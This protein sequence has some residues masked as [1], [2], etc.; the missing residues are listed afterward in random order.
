MSHLQTT[1]GERR[2]VRVHAWLIIV[3]TALVVGLAAVALLSAPTEHV[4]ESEVEVMSRPTRG[5]P[6]PPTMGTERR[7]ALS[8]SVASEAADRMALEVAEAR[9][10]LSVSVVTDSEVLVL[11]YTAADP[12]RALDGA[13]AFTSSYVAE[14]NADQRTRIVDVITEP[15]LLPAPGSGVRPFVLLGA[16]LLAG[17]GLG[18][19]LAFAWDRL[20]DRIRSAGELVR[21]GLPVLVDRLVLPSGGQLRSSALSSGEQGYLATRVGSL[22]EHRRDGVTVLVTCPRSSSGVAPVASLTASSLAASGRRVVLVDLTGEVAEEAAPWSTT[23]SPAPGGERPGLGD[24]LSG[25]CSPEAAMRPTTVEG[26][27]VV[28]PGSSLDVASADVDSV[29]TVLGEMAS[30]NVVVLVGPPMLT[31]GRAWLFA[32]RADLVLLVAEPPHLRRRDALRVGHMLSEADRRKA[33]GWIV[34]TRRRA[35]RDEPRPAPDEGPSD[36]TPASSGTLRVGGPHG[37]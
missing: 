30:S 22:T 37:T 34:L 13:E 19:A 6:I 1:T 25:A 8:G 14:R 10:G 3:T 18:V 33:A 15:A 4:A 28:G 2:L 24:V 26:L 21:T 29:A 20:S 27:R 12:T 32:G 9:K 16:A 7:F 36:P 5:A 35:P 11:R 23:D 31:S 17:L